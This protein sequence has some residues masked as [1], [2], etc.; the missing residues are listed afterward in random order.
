MYDRLEIEDNGNDI[1]DYRR[2]NGVGNKQNKS[3]CDRNNDYNWKIMLEFI[4]VKLN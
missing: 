4:I 1:V 3:G 2:L